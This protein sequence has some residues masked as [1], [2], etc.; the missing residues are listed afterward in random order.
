M[1]IPK[2]KSLSDLAIEEESCGYLGDALTVFVVGASGDLAKKKTYPSLF[3]LF[4]HG[5]L[6]LNTISTYEYTDCIHV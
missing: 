4:R 6:P 3:D 5:F 2:V 1:S